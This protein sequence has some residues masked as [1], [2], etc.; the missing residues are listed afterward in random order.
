MLHHM[1]SIVHVDKYLNKSNFYHPNDVMRKV[2]VC[3]LGVHRTCTVIW[4][5]H[6]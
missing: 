3:K 5:V 6:Y 1:F 4:K 2:F